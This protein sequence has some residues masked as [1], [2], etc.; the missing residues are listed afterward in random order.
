MGINLR[1]GNAGVSQHGLNTAD[2]RAV[3]QQVRG[4]AVAQGVRSNFFNNSGRAAVFFH[5]PLD[6]AGS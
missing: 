5:N 2:V 4:E 3:L 1:S 6:L